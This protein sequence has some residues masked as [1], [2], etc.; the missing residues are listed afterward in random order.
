M[1]PPRRLAALCLPALLALPATASAE[2]F[3]DRVIAG[4]TARAAQVKGSTQNYPTADGLTIPVTLAAGYTGDPAGA[5]TYATFVG[6][7]PHGPELASLRLAVVPSGEIDDACGGDPGAGILACYGADDQ[8]MIVPAD[9]PA[10][11][12]VPVNYV[13][14]HEYGHH[15]ARHRSNAPMEALDFGPKRWASYELVCAQ[16][17]N[18]QLAPGD[19]GENYLHNPGEAWAEAYARLVFP[20]MAWR[21]TRRLKPTA[22]SL[23]A[24][25]ADVAQPWTKRVST[26]F[27]GARTRTFTLPLTLDGAFTLQLSGPARANYD[28]VVRSGGKLVRKTKRTDSRDRIHYPIACRDRRT[29][30]L[31]ITVLKRSGAGRYSLIAKYAG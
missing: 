13:I 25:A 29:E 31:K 24:A 21:F 1:T 9:Q 30:N 5:Q 22:G 26:T 15:I 7:L 19:E 3:K 2:P 20:E 28:I 18:G 11:S 8:T 16:T 27:T 23:L 4:P 12:T 17:L 6:T 10:D 14:A